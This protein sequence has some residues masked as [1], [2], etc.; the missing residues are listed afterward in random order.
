MFGKNKIEEKSNYEM[1]LE[2]L[3][4][5]EK[6]MTQMVGKL[7]VANGGITLDQMLDPMSK[8]VM[9]DSLEYYKLARQQILDNAKIMDQKEKE[10]NEKLDKQ[11]KM[12]EELMKRR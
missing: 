8:I 10:L 3:Q 7:V 4:G 1:V 5:S 12:L 2:A 9:D 6:Y 11:T